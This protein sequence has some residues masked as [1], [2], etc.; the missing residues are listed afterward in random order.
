MARATLRDMPAP[1]RSTAKPRL[2]SGGNPQIAKADG[3]EPVR[4]YIEAMPDWKRDVGLQIDAAIERAV[5]GVARAVKW[6]SPLYGVPEKGWF[7]GLHCF[8]KYVK[9]AFFR[10]SALK[11]LPPVESQDPHARYLHVSPKEPLDLRQFE[12]WVKQAS[13]QPGWLAPKA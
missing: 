7:L 5:P 9:V 12:R 2:L 1:R 6:N 13:K 4:A 3:D 8:A 10:G 11:P